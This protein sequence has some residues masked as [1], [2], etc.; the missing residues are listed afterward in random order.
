MALF[1]A[2]DLDA[3][4]DEFESKEDEVDSD[5][6]V[7]NS[8]SDEVFKATI[9][10]NPSPMFHQNS[11]ASCPKNPSTTA[12]VSATPAVESPDKN[13]SESDQF[14]DVP[15]SPDVEEPE[16]G[17]KVSDDSATKVKPVLGGDDHH[18][19]QPDVLSPVLRGPQ[20]IQSEEKS[21]QDTIND[22]TIDGGGGDPDKSPEYESIYDKYRSP[23]ANE[24]DTTATSEEEA[25]R[26]PAKVVNNGSGAS[27]TKINSTTVQFV[28][29]RDEDV[30]ALLDELESETAL[31]PVPGGARPKEIPAHTQN[32]S[33]TDCQ[34]AAD[35]PAESSDPPDV[36]MEARDLQ[37][38]NRQIFTCRIFQAALLNFR[39]LILLDFLRF[40]HC[41]R[42]NV[43]ISNFAEMS[44]AFKQLLPA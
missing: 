29:I 5:K 36:V 17:V 38:K 9:E 32:G 26:S 37:E 40:S 24:S 28:E 3:V 25:T 39:R 2:I 16:T 18:P 22:H 43:M 34:D 44:G 21:T 1:Q 12:S 35:N 11:S 7:E 41:L 23:R 33:T 8:E 20:Q 27:A 14:Y 10:N 6:K 19:H 31:D 4:L 13:S 15:G 30:D 42:R